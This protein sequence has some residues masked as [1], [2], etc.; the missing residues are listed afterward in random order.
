MPEIPSNPIPSLRA[1]LGQIA[2]SAT[3]AVTTTLGL[4]RLTGG[5]VQ[6]DID[7][8]D[9]V[10]AAIDK[11]EAWATSGVSTAAVTS[12]GVVQGNGIRSQTSTGNTYAYEICSETTTDHTATPVTIYSFSTATAGV[13]DVSATVVAITSDGSE[14][15]RVTLTGT[16][17]SGSQAVATV[18]TNEQDVAGSGVS[19]TLDISGSTVRVRVTGVVTDKHYWGAEI[20]VTVRK[21]A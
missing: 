3:T 18:K 11:L 2:L 6:N 5:L 9:V 1:F 21:A 20:G 16:F 10:N 12:T 17:I 15:Y 4:R 7:V 13:Y 19:A 14:A 8:R